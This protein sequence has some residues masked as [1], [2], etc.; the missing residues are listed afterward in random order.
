MKLSTVT[1]PRESLDWVGG[2]GVQSNLGFGWASTMYE[3]HILFSIQPRLDFLQN[4]VSVMQHPLGVILPATN[5]ISPSCLEQNHCWLSFG[6]IDRYWK[7]WRSKSCETKRSIRSYTMSNQHLT[8][9]DCNGRTYQH[10]WLLQTLAQGYSAAQSK[11]LENYQSFGMVRQKELCSN[12]ES[13]GVGKDRFR[14][15]LRDWAKGFGATMRMGANEYAEERERST[16]TSQRSKREQ[17]L[18]PKGF[19]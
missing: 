19:K 16:R 17:H 2:C 7:G 8:E 13:D 3:Y 14:N 10:W 12:M 4:I 5:A 11:M 15:E 9:H 1:Y 18:R 6:Y